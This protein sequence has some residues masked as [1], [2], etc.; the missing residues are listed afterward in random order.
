M[1]HVIMGTAGHVDHGK[2][3][4]IKALTGIDCD[5]HREEKKRG[6]TI[7][8]GFAHLELDPGT[9]IGIVDVPGHRDFVNTMVGGASGIDFVMMVIAADSGVMPQTREHLQILQVLNVQRGLIALTKVDRIND[10]EWLHLCRSEISDFVQGTFLEDAPMVDV[11]AVTGQGVGE[12][13][14]AIREVI[15]QVEERT[16]AG[17]FRLFVDRLFS[18]SGFG[19][20]VTGSVISGRLSVGDKVFLLPGVNG[21]MAVRRLERHGVEVASVKAGDRASINVAGL[22]KSDFSRGQVITDQPLKATDLVDAELVVFEDV[23]SLGIWSQVIFHTGTFEHQ[24]RLHLLNTDRLNAGGTALVQIHLP[25]PCVLTHGDRFVMRN[26]SSD[27]TL[28]GGRVLD[29]SPQLHRRR[30]KKLIEHL[31]AIA[32]GD[33]S[34]LILAHMKSAPGPINS[35]QIAT[36]LNLAITQV[37][38]TYADRSPHDIV[39]VPTKGEGIAYLSRKRH[40]QIRDAVLNAVT[41]FRK[42]NPMID[43]GINLSEIRGSLKGLGKAED[44]ALDAV[45]MEVLRGWIRSGKINEK[46]GTWAP[47]DGGDTEML[48]AHLAHF[49]EFVRG[50]GMQVPP[51]ENLK[52]E[53][54]RR[55]LSE[56]E[57]K[58]VLFHLCAR[59]TLVRI[60]EHVLHRNVVDRC[61]TRLIEA[62]TADPAGLTISQF[63]DL[64]GGNRKICLLLMAQFDGE[65]LTHRIGDVRVLRADQ[66]RP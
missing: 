19:S 3:A 42:Q 60:Q 14:T 66:R 57:L 17:C 36:D 58:H 59:G 34:D 8:L 37:E 33:L 23:P 41:A 47:A 21:D 9:Q 5:T 62:L 39:A 31:Q 4:L 43:R 10:P 22:T 38:Q 40:V 55:N 65:G 32:A 63:R 29:I 53:A 26:T 11:S 16:D 1:K 12:L 13:K 46:Q 56:R 51:P 49:E 7:N 64:V 50:F 27:R 48:E 2:T 18:V 15:G 44:A 54:A 30:P 52:S 6:I 45:V 35:H 25:E 28:G 24:A 20:V 61:R